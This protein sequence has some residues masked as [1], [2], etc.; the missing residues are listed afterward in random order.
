MRNIYE[1]F[2]NFRI[3]FIKK[4]LKEIINKIKLAKT[5]SISIETFES[6]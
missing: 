2:Q 5:K 3:H 6:Y 1:I 4:K